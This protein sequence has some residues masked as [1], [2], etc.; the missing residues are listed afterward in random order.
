MAEHRPE[1][2]ERIEQEDAQRYPGHEDPESARERAGLAD[3]PSNDEG[4]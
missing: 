3:E 2:G 1:E 4:E